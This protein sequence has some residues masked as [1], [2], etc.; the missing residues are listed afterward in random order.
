MKK[1]ITITALISLIFFPLL[2]QAHDLIPAKDMDKVIKKAKSYLGVPYKYGGISKKGFDCSGLMVKSFAAASFDLPRV[3]SSQQKLGFEVS[4]KNIKKGDL[5]FFAKKGKVNHVGLVTY[6][7]KN[8]VEFIH[9]TTSKGVIISSL[10]ESY[11]KSR[12]H[13]AKRLWD[14][15]SA[16]SIDEAPVV[17]RIEKEVRDVPNSKVDKFRDR[18]ETKMVKKSAKKGTKEALKIE[19]DI[20]EYKEKKKAISTVPFPG[21][22][23]EASQRDLTLA[24]LRKMEA[25]RL[26]LMKYEILA[27]HGFEFTSASLQRYFGMQDWYRELDKEK[28]KKKVIKELSSV[29]LANIKRIAAVEKEKKT[30]T[31]SQH[32][33]KQ[34]NLMKRN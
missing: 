31:D 23:P 30:S 27:R 22:F 11:W 17:I 13:S 32:L 8:K 21:R 3:S 20:I 29:E 6:A 14:D 4:K 1:L 9:S 33:M 19:K 10:S 12:Y 24:E 5:I 28:N 16:P 7:K 34:G 15:N 2:S 26:S 18:K 25:E